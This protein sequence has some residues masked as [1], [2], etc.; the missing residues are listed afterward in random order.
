MENRA[1]ERTKVSENPSGGGVVLSPT[2]NLTR[3]SQIS[4][5]RRALVGDRFLL[6]YLLPI[7]ILAVGGYGSVKLYANMPVHVPTPKNEK[8]LYVKVVET[9]PVNLRPSFTLYGTTVAGREI[10]MRSRVA[11]EVIATGHGL[12]DGAVV[13]KGERLLQIEPFDFKG[14]VSEVNTRIDETKAQIGEIDASIA[15]ERDALKHARE[16]LAFARADLLRA[17]ELIGRKT[18]SAKVA[19]DRRTLVSQRSQLVAAHENS[20][21]VLN[22]RTNR[23]IAVLARLHWKLSQ[24]KRRLAE[25]TLSAPFDGYV[26]KV[27]AQVGRMLNTNDDVATIIDKHWIEAR[28]VLSKHQFARLLSD[29]DGVIG[30]RVSVRWRLGEKTLVY[31]ATIERLASK[32]SATMG[33]ME[34]IARVDNPS[35]PFPLRPGAFV[36]VKVPD[37]TYRGVVRLPQAALYGEDT[38]F[39][40]EQGELVRRSVEVVGSAGGDILVQGGISKGD[41]VVTSRLSHPFAGLRVQEL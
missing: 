8:T 13:A 41:R 29:D 26:A 12:R 14:A 17:E 23:Q 35:Q 32:I 4:M 37:K 21:L 6:R 25:T 19:D 7:I 20:I 39:V 22:A 24:A 28:F 31:P 30:R 9:S 38:V 10:L 36:E 11:G 3:D 33:G 16:Q 34:I 27:N 18:I 1:A 15:R 40:V 2:P 5:S